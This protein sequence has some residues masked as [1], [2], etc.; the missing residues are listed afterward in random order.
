MEK[1]Q[2]TGKVCVLDIDMQVGHDLVDICTMTFSMSP[3]QG[4]RN[5]KETDLN[6]LY[7]F[8]KPPT[9]EELV[10]MVFFKADLLLIATTELV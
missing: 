5:I 4:V 8:I 6:P 2:S 9:I 7:I 3:P 10:R 1:V